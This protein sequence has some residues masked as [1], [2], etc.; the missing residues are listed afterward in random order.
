MLNFLPVVGLI[1]PIL[2]Y[3]VFFFVNSAVFSAIGL[4]SDNMLTGVA[5][6]SVVVWIWSGLYARSANK[7]LSKRDK[8]DFKKAFGVNSIVEVS[9]LFI[10]LFVNSLFGSNNIFV[11]GFIW[12]FMMY[13]GGNALRLWLTKMTFELKTGEATNANKVIFFV[14]TLIYF[15]AIGYF[16]WLAI[17]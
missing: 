6:F 14:E 10:M 15:P 8:G 17:L 16:G 13:V 9:Q 5:I 4:S 1:A 11:A 2:L 12:V 7:F 3:L